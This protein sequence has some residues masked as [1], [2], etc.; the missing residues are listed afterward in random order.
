[1]RLNKFLSA[2]GVCSRRKADELIENGEIIVNGKVET[3]LG[4]NIDEKKDKII[5][6]GK[7]ISLTSEFVYYK[8]NKPKGYI[9]SNNDDKGRKTIFELLPK[10]KR[11]FSIGRLDYN[12]EGLIL[13]TN[14][15]ELS[16]AISHPRYEVNKEYIVTIEGKILESELA[17]LRAGVVEKGI[18]MPKA[19]VQRLETD[20]KITKISVIINEGQNRQV[21][22]MFE[23][24][25][26]TIILL[27]RVRIGE[28][29]L[30]G[31]QRGTYKELNRVEM[32]YIN[33]LK[34]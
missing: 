20:G 30:G 6:N 19:R 7:V 32:E 33:M 29:T 25:G 13:I 24:I 5:Y 34:N 4:T 27:K 12:T 23:A 26:K 1:M 9:C 8:L 17:V 21:R 15:G 28:I 3:Q 2:S 22:R 14:D 31:L 11:L 16:E 18:R 10:D